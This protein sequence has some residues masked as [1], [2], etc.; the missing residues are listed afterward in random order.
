MKAIF[1]TL[2]YVFLLCTLAG[3]SGEKESTEIT[4]QSK[5]PEFS[6]TEKARIEEVTDWY[7]AV[8]TVRPEVEAYISAQITAKITEILLSPGQSFKKGDLLVRLD[9][10][11][12]KASL[13]RAR[14][15]LKQ[16]RSRKKQATQGVYGARAVYGQAEKEYRRIQKFFQSEAAT[17]SNLEQAEARYLKAKAELSRSRAA[18]QSAVAGIGDAENRVREASIS[19]EYADIRAG[20]DGTVLKRL[21][22]PGNITQPGQPLL[23]VKADGGMILAAFVREG[24]INRVKK[25]SR[26]KAY[27]PP[28]KRTFETRIKEIVPYA[29]PETRTFLVKAALPEDGQLFAGMFGKLLLPLSTVRIVSV[30]E[31]AVTRVGQLELVSVREED[32]WEKRFV[33]TGARSGDR[34][35]VI[36]GLEGFETI[37]Y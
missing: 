20:S 5:Q 30:P 36:S 8:G 6:S 19:A 7:E 27:I 25:D 14:D 29:D 32:R 18:L 21:A 34:V 2:F 9:K 10:R 1:R 26:F 16:A 12:L 31:K 22:E 15:G 33:K 23:T 24:M 13:S 11:R 35:E 28:L 37:G 4:G 3:C 17:R